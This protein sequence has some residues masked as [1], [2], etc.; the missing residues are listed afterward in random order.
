MISQKLEKKIIDAIAG[1]IEGVDASVQILG[2]WQPSTRG[3]L[4]NSQDSESVAVIAVSIGTSQRE[5]FSQPSVRY[6]G[7]VVLNVRTALD[8]TGEILLA[9]ADRLDKLFNSWQAA[10]Y[11]SAFSDLD[12]DGVFQVGDI[13]LLGG[14]ID[15]DEVRSTVSWSFTLSGSDAV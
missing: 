8:S 15:F 9:L 6:T 3:V 10:T 14:P 12:V 11:Q 13:A 4:K 1:A 2:A 7:A 5:T